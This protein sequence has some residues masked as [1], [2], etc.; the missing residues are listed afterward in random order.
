MIEK[1][2]DKKIAM[3]GLGIENFSLVNYILKHKIP[4]EITVCD[5]KN[6][7]EM[8][9][10]YEELSQNSNIKWKLGDEF[11]K[12]LDSFDIVFRSPGWPTFCPGIQQALR[13]K[14]ALS[15]AMKLFFEVCPTKN[16][17]GVTGTKG[18]GTTS[19]LLYE[20]IQASGQKV[21]LGGNIGT[22]PFDFID[23][24][25]DN[26]WVVLELSSF[27]LENMNRS[28]HI[29]VITNFV[30]EHLAPADPSNPN[31]HK[32]AREYWRAKTNI[33]RWQTSEDKLI[34]NRT[35]KE[36]ISEM[37]SR[38]ET[39]YFEESNL[40]SRLVGR[41]NRE[42]VAAA[43]T[44]ARLIGIDDGT[45]KKTVEN[46]KGLEHR[47]EFVAE[48]NGVKYFN[49]SFA[50]TPESAITA[51]NSFQ[52]PIILLAGGAEKGSDFGRLARK[53]KEKVKFVVLFNGKATLRLK[54]EILKV[55]FLKNKIR[56][57]KNMKEALAFAKM[58][59][60]A[61]DIILLSPACASFG[62]F[63]NYKERGNLFKDMAGKK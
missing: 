2:K 28:P 4:C 37:A 55:G 36:K 5:K 63:K 16:I 24:I 32:S 44:V 9:A 31:Y 62:I 54:S 26:D 52:E 61:G 6:K 57:A 34:L 60:A 10:R 11:N 49:D 59:A 1:I 22:S 25:K 39:I 14:T 30:K 53:I 27:Q 45:I 21:F 56:P 12:E 42:N 35:L 19:S 18:K 23:E 51:I 33:Y 50:T 15:S 3:L 13:N 48:K 41:H 47:I 7:E 40:E 17:I 43:E 58:N 38:G 8:D 20:I 29:A 46:F